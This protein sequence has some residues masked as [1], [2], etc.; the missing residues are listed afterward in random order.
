MLGEELNMVWLARRGSIAIDTLMRFADRGL[1]F[2][3]QT[4]LALAGESP[5]DISIDPAEPRLRALLTAAHLG[6]PT[7]VALAHLSKAAECWRGGHDA[8]AAMHLVLSRLDRLT[9]PEAD[10]HRLFLAD[11]LLKRGVE[12]DAVI[13]AVGAGILDRLEKYDPN[14]PRVPSGSGQASG[15]WTADGARLPSFELGGAPNVLPPAPASPAR[16][17]GSAREGPRGARTSRGTRQ[18]SLALPVLSALDDNF[19]FHPNACRTARNFCFI[20]AK[21]S[22]PVDPFGAA[23]D[24][25]PPSEQLR[26]EREEIRRVKSCIYAEGMCDLVDVVVFSAPIP[27]TGFTRFPDG[28]VVV[29][30]QGDEEGMYFPAGA[31][32]RYR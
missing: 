28:G 23:N 18:G 31:P 1:V 17:P 8:L 5:R 9:H 25:L 14:E 15:Q 13:A 26:I 11:G 3:A 4:T 32:I 24:N 20:H 2:G 21:Q 12:P 30:R 29:I 7:E 27:I 6:Q 22:A 10:A 19:P 16:K